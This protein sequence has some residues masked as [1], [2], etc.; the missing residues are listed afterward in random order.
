MTL[1]GAWHVVALAG[2]GRRVHHRHHQD[3]HQDEATEH[4]QRGVQP[5]GKGLLIH[6]TWPSRRRL[7]FSHR[8]VR[9]AQQRRVE[10]DIHAVDHGGDHRL[11]F[12]Q[13]RRAA[14]LGGRE[15][16]DQA[17]HGTKQPDAD[18]VRRQPFDV[19]PT[20]QEDAQDAQAG[21]AHDQ[22][23][24]KGIV[25]FERLVGDAG[26]PQADDAGG[27]DRLDHDTA[28]QESERS[29]PL[30]RRRGTRHRRA[31]S[32][33]CRLPAICIARNRAMMAATS[34]CGPAPPPG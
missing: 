30:Q 19:A 12:V 16:D 17:D 28:R 3:R 27:A 21:D 13:I 14:G 22:P 10:R 6:R 2:F 9:D 7:I 31:L 15:R 32:A 8:L 11:D 24:Q 5:D 1:P 26:D 20:L 25:A 33:R 34:G 23:A 29:P 4:Q 18:D